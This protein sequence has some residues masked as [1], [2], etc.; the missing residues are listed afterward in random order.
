MHSS[1][2]ASITERAAAPYAVGGEVEVQIV[3][4]TNEGRGLGRLPCTNGTSWVVMVPFALPNETVKCRIMDNFKSYRYDKIIE[5]KLYLHHP[6]SPS[7]HKVL[8]R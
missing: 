7:L 8:L 2:H 3:E 1:K 6:S 5:L 4:L